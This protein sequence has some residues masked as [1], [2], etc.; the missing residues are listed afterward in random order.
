[1]RFDNTKVNDNLCK[2]WGG[3]ACLEPTEDSRREKSRD[4]SVGKLLG[5]L[6]I[7]TTLLYFWPFIA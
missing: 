1:M 5:S 4:I 6:K 2:S 3:D 7:F